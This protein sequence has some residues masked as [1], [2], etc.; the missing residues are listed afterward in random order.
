MSK[1]KFFLVTLLLLA[2]Q[3]LLEHKANAQTQNLSLKEAITLAVKNNRQ[4]KVSHL[5][6]QR[7]AQQI[8]VAKSKALPTV[9]LSSQY[10]HYFNQPVFF[11]LGSGTPTNDKIPYS[12]F[13]GDDQLTA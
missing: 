6:I 10:V 1:S 7:S 13:G 2:L 11:G 3:L 5:D 12:R 8:T 4:L 9:N